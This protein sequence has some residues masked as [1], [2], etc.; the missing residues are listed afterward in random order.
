MCIAG[1]LFFESSM[2]SEFPSQTTRD[3]VS[4]AVAAREYLDRG[5]VVGIFPEG[6]LT[7]TGTMQAFA[8]GL[9]RIIKNRN[10]V[11]LPAY[12]YKIWGSIFSFERGK[13]LLK[14]SARLDLFRCTQDVR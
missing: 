13:F 12:V 5:E 1:A 10:G 6:Q 2:R 7:R 11:I 4:L 3:D 14:L 8:R 9:Q